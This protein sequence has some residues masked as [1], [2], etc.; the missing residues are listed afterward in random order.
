MFKCYKID[1]NKS[2]SELPTRTQ[3]R[4]KQA[5]SIL[6][7][8]IKKQDGSMWGLFQGVLKNTELNSPKKNTIDDNVYAG[9]GRAI[10]MKAFNVIKDY[11]NVKS[12]LS[13]ID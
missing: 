12:M 11:I 5:S 1:L 6:E 7:G 9:S 8:E 3:N 4:I 13:A 2:I 10:N